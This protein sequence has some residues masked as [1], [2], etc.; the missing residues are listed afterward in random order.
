MSATVKSLRSGELAR[1]TGVSSDTIRHYERMGILPESPRTASGY[2]MYGRNAVDRVR[3]V[4]HAL[5]LGFTLAE[6]SEILQARDRGGAP[7]HRV[8]NLAEEKLRALEQRIQELH[9][10]QRYMRQLVRQWRVKLAHTAA[11]DKAMLLHSLA[12]NSVPRAKPVDNFRRR[13]KS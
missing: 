9:R 8:L 4:Q 2:R 10:T 7:C 1:L 3:L 5:Q 12:D 13:K 11:G 6:L